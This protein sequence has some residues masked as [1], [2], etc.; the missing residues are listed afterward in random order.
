MFKLD[1]ECGDAPLL[2]WQYCRRPPKL[3]AW[4][5][6]VVT[7]GLLELAN[8]DEE[9]SY[10]YGH[11]SLNGGFRVIP[12]WRCIEEEEVIGRG[13]DDTFQEEMCE[14]IVENRGPYVSGRGGMGKSWML[15]LLGPKFKALGYDV[16]Y[17]VFTH[18]VAANLDGDTILHELNR[19]AQ[20]KR[21]VVIVDECSM[22]PFCMWPH[23]R[24]EHCYCSWRHV[25]TVSADPGPQSYAFAGGLRQE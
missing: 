18:V 16:H 11:C 8:M 4:R 7:E 14:V 5:R 21:L 13:S 3:N 10:E 19:Y 1:D 6:K 24:R 9:D 12:E 20:S 22:V 2:E 15:K 25:W 17:I 23:L